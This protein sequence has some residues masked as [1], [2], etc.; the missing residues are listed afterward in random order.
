MTPYHGKVTFFRGRQYCFSHEYV[1]L[2]FLPINS[3][4]PE[5]EDQVEISFLR[6]CLENAMA[7]ELTPYERDI[8]RLRLGLDSGEGKTVPQIVELCGGS[9]TTA[10]VR[11]AER[12]A[13]RKLR[14]PNSVHT[15]NLL[16]YL[17][18][19]DADRDFLPRRI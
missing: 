14:S 9:I 1:L 12:K 8:L 5:P 19:S 18:M 11:A 17:D 2:T 13:L 15:H 16:A 10:D 6:Q 4:E 3:A 7:T